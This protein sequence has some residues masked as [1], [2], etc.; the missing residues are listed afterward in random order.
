MC[1][2]GALGRGSWAFPKRYRWAIERTMARRYQMPVT[3][4]IRRLQPFAR[5]IEFFVPARSGEPMHYLL[6]YEVAENYAERR[7]EFRT[8]HLEKATGRRASAVNW[9]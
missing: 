7:A 6:F 8:A 2:T 4:V 9:C 5:G 3:T 1:V